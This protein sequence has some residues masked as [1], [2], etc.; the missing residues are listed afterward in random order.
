MNPV[1]WLH[2]A[3]GLAALPL[4]TLAAAARKGGPVHRRAGA[5]FALA[6]L[7][8]GITAALLE[9]YRT[10]PGSPVGGIIVCYFVAT[11][12]AA[13]RRR[14]GIGW[15]ELVACALAFSLA[16]AIG[17][18]ALTGSTT[19]TDS[20]QLFVLAALCLLAGAGDLRAAL[21]GKLS[22]GQRLAR[23]LWRMCFAFFIATGSF[24]L[25]QQQ[26]LPE[27]VRGSP[28]LF[29]LA[30]APLVFMLVWLVR[31]RFAKTLAKLTL[32]LPMTPA[33]AQSPRREMEV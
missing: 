24:F 23:H 14:E 33:V 28:M 9:P 4:G 18:G 5:L 11:G 25:G 2:I 17:L 19:P 16:A 21:P 32:R 27:A 10:P 3:A 13:G 20:G 7:L 12:Y 15:F 26:V 6:M 22:A 1:L 31:I 30:F 29:V 8:L